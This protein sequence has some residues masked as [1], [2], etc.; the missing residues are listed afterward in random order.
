MYVFEKRNYVSAKIWFSDKKR[1]FEKKDHRQE[2]HMCKDT[3]IPLVGLLSTNT[4]VES[5]T[6]IPVHN[7][8][9]CEMIRQCLPQ[10]FENLP[11]IEFAAPSVVS[12]RLLL[13]LLF[14]VSKLY[15]ILQIEKNKLTYR[16][17]VCTQNIGVSGPRFRPIEVLKLAKHLCCET[18]KGEWAQAWFI[19]MRTQK[20]SRTVTF[21]NKA[22]GS[23]NCYSSMFALFLYSINAPEQRQHLLRQQTYQQTR[24]EWSRRPKQVVLSGAVC[25]VSDAG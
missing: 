25:V 7:N 12:F 8:G 14:H 16:Q 11:E 6:V 19:S 2:R 5:K 21:E 1:C 15:W 23:R 17:I 3:K 22:L 24:A 13:F 9:D 18:P 20:P 4:L 10:D